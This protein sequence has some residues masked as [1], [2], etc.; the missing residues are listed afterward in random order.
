[1]GHLF[2]EKS[3]LIDV[4]KIQPVQPRPTAQ[5]QKRNDI[6]GLRAFAIVSVLVYHLKPA[7][8]PYG[9]IGVDM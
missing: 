6:Q 9:Y 4:V 3:L 8:L 1:M 7:W 2:D 5:H